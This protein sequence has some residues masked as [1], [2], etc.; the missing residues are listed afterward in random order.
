MTTELDALVS[1]TV[2]GKA[3]RLASSNCECFYCRQPIGAKHKPS[4]VLVKKRVK[5]RMAVEYEIEVPASWGKDQIE[6]QR[7]EGSWCSN[8]ALDE[9]DRAFGKDDG[10]CMC[11]ATTFEYIGG[12]SAPYVDE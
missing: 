2:T 11:G 9:L 5:V 12:D 10:P 8:N 4:C 3:M 1:F 7:N 6:F